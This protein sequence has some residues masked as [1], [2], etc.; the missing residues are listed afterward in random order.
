MTNSSA[1]S[2]D[3][4]S[5]NLVPLTPEYLEEEHG[6]YVR[7]IDAALTEPKIKNIAL[8]GNY[9]VGKSSILQ[10][11]AENHA[12]KVVEISLSTLA[13]KIEPEVEDTIPK[14]AATTTNRIQQEIVKQLLY[15]EEPQKLTGSR[16]RR[17]ERFYWSREIGIAGILGF[18][19]S[20]VFLLAGW[21]DTISNTL[22]P[23]IF[24][25]LYDHLAM[26]VMVASSVIYFRWLFHGR[27]RIT[28]LS[29]GAATVTLDEKSM[30]YFDQ[31]LDE[32][33]H[34]FEVSKRNIVIFEDIDRFDDPHIFETLRALNTLLNAPR[35][36][37]QAIRFIYAIKDSIFDIHCLNSLSAETNIKYEPAYAEVVR[38]NRTKFFDL[39][40]PVVPFIT[41]RSAKS[42]I[43]RLLKDIEHDV[44]P[45]LLDLASRYVPD[46]RLLKNIRNEFIVF[47]ERIFS[48]DGK[49]LK[50]TQTELFAMML[51]KSTHLADFEAIRLGKSN[52]DTLYNV[53]RSL[54]SENLEKLRKGI[55][56][57][58]RLLHLY[59]RTTAQGLN[60]RDKL[61]AL[62]KRTARSVGYN[63]NNSKFS[64]GGRVLSEQ[65]LG[66]AEFWRKFFSSEENSHLTWTNPHYGGVLNFE[67]DDLAEAFGI[68]IEPYKWDED[69]RN[70]LKVEIDEN[71]DDID[72]V[73]SADMGDFVDR[74]HFE[75]E[76]SGSSKTFA[77]IATEIL[78]D[79]LAYQLVRAGFINRN[80]T[81]YTSTFHKDRVGPAAQNFII[82]NVERNVMD[83]YFQ[84]S[85][86]DVEAVLRECGDSA[87]KEHAL[88]N[89]DILNY[90]LKFKS[91]KVRIMLTSF[92]SEGAEQKRFMHTYLSSGKRSARFVQHLSYIFPD[93]LTYLIAATEL[94]DLKRRRLISVVLSNL[95]G[96]VK[97]KIGGGVEKYITEKYSF[98]S[99]LTSE[100]VG[101]ETIKKIAEFFS[102][103]GLCVDK[104][105][106]LSSKCQQEFIALSLYPVSREN[107]GLVFENQIS[108]ALDIALDLDNAVY[109]YLLQNL[110]DYLV[111]VD[112]LSETISSND[113]LIRVLEDVLKSHPSLLDPVIAK[114]SEG[115][116]VDN[117]DQISSDVW[118]YLAK[119]NRFKPTFANI[120][121]Y[122]EEI[123]KVDSNLSKVLESANQ[124]LES[125]QFSEEK[126]QSVAVNILAARDTLP[127]A[128]LRVSLVNSLNLEDYLNIDDLPVEKG[129]LF[130]LLLKE[131]LL[132]DSIESY[133]HIAPTD[134]PTRE[135]FIQ[136]SEN[137]KNFVTTD[138]ADCNIINIL[139][140]NKVSLSVKNAI[141]DRA[142]EFE[143]VCTKED[144]RQIGQT[145][146]RLD[147]TI[148]IALIVNMPNYGVSNKDVLA[149]LFPHL[150]AIPQKQLFEV[151]QNM[152]GDYS[153]LT[154]VGREVIKISDTKEI[155]AVLDVLK[156]QG[157]VSKVTHQAGLLYVYRRHK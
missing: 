95:N 140:S 2:T 120:N 11:V 53:Y 15:R 55:S 117:I 5:W 24:L 59:T 102:N 40:V 129:E 23:L 80:F 76:Y 70:D 156:Q 83:E 20:V 81:L 103:L 73:R 77:F 133:T 21:T 88:Y 54:V 149:L 61:I 16:F 115:C 127:S 25:G 82:H 87:L 157:I 125:S 85:H 36:G 27:L 33:V 50:L 35:S 75:V 100:N 14:Q 112:G 31:Y 4:V 134:W 118:P 145:A 42:L 1:T 69:Y 141:L 30:S 109:K 152:G 39:V 7:A 147:R 128:Q 34:F 86:E 9:G 90:L 84:L 155:L 104:L 139:T 63:A 47:R 37:K 138:L 124:I 137:F 91:H 122:L 45:E 114:S 121:R 135:M 107:I 116:I 57:K 66:S 131:E 48:G 96:N 49:D 46:M 74:I 56:E 29:A 6:G 132:E 99:V 18:I 72:F 92:N 28:Q 148:P 123:G 78:R 3:K 51:Y 62:S 136:Q 58:R 111:A 41:H 68:S 44:S 52:L 17:I 67:K 154:S 65:E 32:I 71:I 22:M 150:S 110:Q 146:L 105:A 38:A 98:F 94:S 10:Q 79:G 142:V 13:P 97:Y 19:I 151:L 106:P 93:I 113:N 60:L 64:H 26:M 153:R 108:S 126:K 130:A 43:Y 143:S 89:L 119:Y 8:S 144:L 12:S 101:Q